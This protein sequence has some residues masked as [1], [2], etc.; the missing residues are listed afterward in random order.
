MTENE[1]LTPMDR[2]IR[3]LNDLVRSSTE[4]AVYAAYDEALDAARDRRDAL[5]KANQADYEQT[6]RS[7][8]A[9]IETRVVEIRGI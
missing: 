9:L 7:L 6:L 1:N 2:L 8:A 5:E 4:E 3:A